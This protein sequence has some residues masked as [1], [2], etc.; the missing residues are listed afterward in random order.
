MM[1]S[2]FYCPHCNGALNAHE[3]ICLIIKDVN[4]KKALVLLNNEIGNYQY[5]VNNTITLKEGDKYNF[6][7]PICSGQLTYK[8]QNLAGMIMEDKNGK[9][10]NIIFSEIL[11][12]NCTYQIVDDKII[13]YGKDQDKYV[14][15][16]NLSFM[17]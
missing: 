10:S 4:D 5:Y 14:N 17:I 16:E 1:K 6:F 8:D 15:F 13:R 2:N 3:H 9:K 7:C 12:E 11:G